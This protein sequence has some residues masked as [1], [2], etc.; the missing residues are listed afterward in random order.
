M[1]V[2]I[3]AESNFICVNYGFTYIFEVR[4]RNIRRV[5]DGLFPQKHCFCRKSSIGLFS[6]R[7]PKS[8]LWSTFYDDGPRSSTLRHSIFIS[9]NSRWNFFA[10]SSAFIGQW[11]PF[12]SYCARMNSSYPKLIFITPK[13]KFVLDLNRLVP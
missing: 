8:D 12:V 7:L 4:I 10:F 5:F 2:Q 11:S 1:T 6:I 9:N 3:S 13:S